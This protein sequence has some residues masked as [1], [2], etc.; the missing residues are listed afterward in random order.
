MANMNILE[1]LA[2]TTFD[3][4]EGY[5][6]AAEKAND[7]DLKRQLQEHAQRRHATLNKLNAEIETAGGASVQ[8]G[9]VKGSLHRVWLDID[10]AFANG[11]EAAAERVEEGEDY[12][13]RKFSEALDSHLDASTRTTVQ[14]CFDEICNGETFGDIIA[15]RYDQGDPD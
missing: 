1:D 15:S 12:L 13:A 5:S 2:R 8:E 10:S 14:E 3:S 4:I 9:S 7:P 6:K 11:D